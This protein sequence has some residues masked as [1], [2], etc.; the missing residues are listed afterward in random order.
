MFYVPGSDESTENAHA[1]DLGIMCR[2]SSAPV[3]CQID[4]CSS[5]VHARGLC[6]KHYIRWRKV[7]PGLAKRRPWDEAFWARVDK[8]GPGGCWLWTGHLQPSGYARTR[9]PSGSSRAVHLIV[10]EMLVGPIPH[11]MQI[12]HVCHTRAC[13]GGSSCA[14]RRC[15]NPQHLQPVTPL[16][17]LA[18]SSNFIATNLM[19]SHCPRGHP[20]SGENLRV[21]SRGARECRTCRNEEMR[22]YYQ[23]RKGRLSN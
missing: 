4:G 20:Y 8:N 7:N 18:R 21:N 3:I 9:T 13:N 22:L 16:Q 10:Y 11:G 2:M 15:C 14:H 6:N 1:T 19:T 23:R 5:H 17:N 12:D